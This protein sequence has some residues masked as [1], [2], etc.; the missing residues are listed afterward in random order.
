MEK[1]RGGK[2]YWEGKGDKGMKGGEEIANWIGKA[3]VKGCDVKPFKFE[4]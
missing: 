2:E 3:Q 1:A 4:Q